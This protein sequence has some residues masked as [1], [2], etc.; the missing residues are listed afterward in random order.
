[1]AAGITAGLSLEHGFPVT[2]EPEPPGS[3][4]AVKNGA[5]LL[6]ENGGCNCTSC[7]A[8]GGR[9]ATA[10][11]EAPGVNFAYTTERLRK[12]YYQRWV[13]HPLRIDP[14]TKMP[15]FADDE[16]KTPLTTFYDGNAHDQFEAIWQYLRTLK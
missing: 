1:A 6:G 3:P 7:H 10:V 11:F 5:T 2:P 16:G 4:E 13:L 8:V 12:S 15:R 9:P 14:E